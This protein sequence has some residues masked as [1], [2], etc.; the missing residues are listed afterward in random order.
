[1]RLRNQ[2]LALSLLTLL[3]PWSGWK[4]VQELENFLREA[5]ENTLVESAQMVSRALPPE[6][7]AE[8]E[9]ARG[10][11]LPLRQF[12]IPPNLDGFISDWSE[13]EQGL[14]FE[15]A[16]KELQLKVLAG[17][18]RTQFYLAME[19]TD[20]AYIR[21]TEFNTGTSDSSQKAGLVLFI[22][23]SRSQ[24]SF[25]ISTEAPGQLVLNSQGGTGQQ[26]VAAWE[27]MA[28]GYR[29]EL[30]LPADTERISIGAVAPS[31]S[32]D[33]V[34]AERYAGTLKGR[35]Q[36]DWLELVS[37][38]NDVA[39]W[40]SKTAPSQSRAWLIQAE[41]WVLADSGPAVA[42]S[43]SELTWV[44]RMIYQA[45]SPSRMPLR[46]KPPGWPVRFET[47]ETS[48]A[49]QGEVGTLWNRDDFS[50]A[51]YNF[52]AVPV[53]GA[54]ESSA[55]QA[56]K[57]IGAVV[58][59]TRSEGLLLMTNRALG[60]FSV[61][62]L[63]LVVVLAAGLWL[64]ASRLSSR[65]Q[66][67]SG[68]VSL[69]M[70][71]SG[72]VSELPLTKSGD[73]LG[74]LARNTEKLLRAVTQY[75]NYLQKLAGRLSHELKTPIA[76]TRSS[77]ENLASQEL[78][79]QA[80]QYIARAQEGLDRQAAIVRAMSEAQRLEG[81]VK[82]AD[83][84]TINLGEMLKHS[85]AAYR[86]VNPSRMINLDVP[87]GGCKLRCAPD[88]ISQALDKLVDNAIGLSADDCEITIALKQD[89]GNCLLSVA[90]SG[91]RLPDVLHEQLFDSLVS[92]RKAK[93][94]NQHLGLGLYIV[95]LVAEAHAGS[96]SARN[97]PD[98]QGVE[99]TICI[100]LS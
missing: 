94:G 70:D 55:G 12:T 90:N 44:Q 98:D 78:D 11:I 23:T 15:S 37:R 56:G 69:A 75:T 34:S 91:T 3:L 48:R 99:F 92:L 84:D 54:G 74:E 96:V 6:Y 25:M 73:E 100:P 46:Q 61:I 5:E 22:Q 81:S 72:K 32:E 10:R 82:T 79:P 28:D 52:V 2:L 59:E 33:S 51:V 57:V 93:A 35:Q 38:E 60:R 64:F 1:M 85:V 24:H 83:W 20:S 36:G 39:S 87:A 65:V 8:L 29:V 97:L 42:A 53:F 76:I 43:S 47:G 4:L 21:A 89:N 13:V 45:V 31:I 58:L 63:M 86:S 88:L 27:N 17:R 77:L 62:A 41:G 67:L 30:S 50:A 71:E 49:M 80:Q 7:K 16:D 26:L 19:V 66:R 14:L 95:R 9:L 40:L 68:A 18:Y